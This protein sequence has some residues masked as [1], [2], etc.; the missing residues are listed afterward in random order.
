MGIFNSEVFPEAARKCGAVVLADQVILTDLEIEAVRAFVSDGGA[1]IVT[2]GTGTRSVDNEPLSDF[3]LADVLGV[4]WKGMADSANCYLRIAERDERFGIPAMDIHIPGGY[5]RVVPTT[6]RTLIELVPPY[7][8]I[9]EGT[10]P[11]D[12]VPEGPGVTVNTYGKGK[13]LYCAPAL[14]S[15]YHSAGTPVLRR[16]ALRLLAEAYPEDKRI[17]VLE[18]TPVNV[19]L[20]FNHRGDERFVHLVNYSGDKRESGVPQTQD[21]PDIHG[22]SVRVR[23]P[24]EPRSITL[25][26]EGTDIP[27]IFKDGWAEFQTEPLG[28]HAVYRIV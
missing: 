2:A 10:P 20:F 15:A 27:F 22:I 14:F 9:A 4:Q 8:G 23:L 12:P 24:R 13:A 26:P 21:F 17:I 28:I 11:P 16:L 25:V 7:E 5:A 1:L 19:E 3:A 6:A 18:N